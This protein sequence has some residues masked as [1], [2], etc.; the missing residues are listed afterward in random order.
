MSEDPGPPTQLWTQNTK[1]KYDGKVRRGHKM[2]TNYVAGSADDA[3][4]AQIVLSEDPN[5][6]Y[7]FPIFGR[8]SVNAD[9]RKSILCPRRT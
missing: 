2:G 4:C 5:L 6:K 9:R 7:I 3:K 8:N 1:R